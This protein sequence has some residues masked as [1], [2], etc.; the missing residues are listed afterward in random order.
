MRIYPSLETSPLKCIP[1]FS[2]ML[3]DAP[4]EN[5]CHLIENL[6]KKNYKA[7]VVACIPENG[8]LT[9]LNPEYLGTSVILPKSLLIVL[10]LFER[11]SVQIS[12]TV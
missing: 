11:L 4:L 3:L 6:S 1:V 10:Q 9:L 5:W 12:L 7:T 8:G 2:I